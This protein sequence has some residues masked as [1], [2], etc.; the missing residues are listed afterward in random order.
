MTLGI[1]YHMPFWR[2][3]DGSLRE[4]E[5]SFARYV[6]SLA[7]Y[8]DEIALC[9]PVI[10]RPSGEGTAIRSTNV[11]L[12]PLPAKHTDSRTTV[13]ETNT[14][15]IS[16][17]DIAQR[18]DTCAG[19][20]IRLLSVSRIDPRKGLRVLPATVQAMIE[21]GIDAT[22]DIIGPTVGQPGE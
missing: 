11:T 1:V 20:S 8:F 9:V 6:D 15:T 16:E 17:H 19:P 13:I 3:A 7:P 5:G 22:L 21:S 18:T 10:D 2:A 14:T 12:A 4:V